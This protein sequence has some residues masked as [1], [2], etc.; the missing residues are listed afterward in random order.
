MI[1]SFKD[2]NTEKVSNGEFVRAFPHNIQK[3]ALRKL[4]TLYVAM[5]L[6]D[7]RMN[8]GNHLEKLGGDRQ[9]QYSIPINKQ[10]RIAFYWENNHAHQ[11]E[12]IDYH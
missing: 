1:K 9:G 11:V 6:N 2:K 10:W 3:R 8:P 7:L 5:S 4:D 12:I